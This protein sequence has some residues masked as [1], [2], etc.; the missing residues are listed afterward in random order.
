MEEVGVVDDENAMEIDLQAAVAEDE[1]EAKEQE[2]EEQPEM[3]EAEAW[4]EYYDELAELP[5][6]YNLV[7]GEAR[8]KKRNSSFLC[9]CR[10]FV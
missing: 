4:S 10:V 8:C 5:Y 3:T 9:S 1:E 2:E 6:Y 7:T